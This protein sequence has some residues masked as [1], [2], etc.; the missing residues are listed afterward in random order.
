MY[1]MYLEYY[2]D[3]EQSLAKTVIQN[4][5]KIC[6][7]IFSISHCNYYYLS[8]LDIM[9]ARLVPASKRK[10]NK[11]VAYHKPKSIFQMD[12]SYATISF[13]EFLYIP[14]AST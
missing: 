11:A 5:E 2:Q 4:Y 6:V 8:F 14:F 13:E 12:F 1:L 10:E 3:L 7:L 9:L